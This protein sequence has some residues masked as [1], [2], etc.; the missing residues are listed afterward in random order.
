MWRGQSGVEWARAAGPLVGILRHEHDRAGCWGGSGSPPGDSPHGGGGEFLGVHLYPWYSSR[1]ANRLNR[2]E[3][4]NDSCLRQQRRVGRT[5][6]Q[7]RRYGKWR[8][9]M[10]DSPSHQVGQSGSPTRTSRRAI[11]SWTLKLAG[12]AALAASVPGTHWVQLAAAQDDEI[13]LTAAASEIGARPGDAYANGAA[14]RAVASSG[15]GASTQGAGR[16]CG[17]E[18]RRVAA[19]RRR[20]WRW[21]R[22]LFRRWSRP[23]HWRRRRRRRWHRWR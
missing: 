14:A 7:V 12:G 19:A 8:V 1:H 17:P 4:W 13:I 20:H 18:H 10:Q 22:R 11:V 16:H 9:E 5:G 3:A 15:G 21:P 6:R 2:H 23:R